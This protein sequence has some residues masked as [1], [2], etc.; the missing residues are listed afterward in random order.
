MI[1]NKENETKKNLRKSERKEL[2]IPLG[3]RPLHIFTETQIL[4]ISKG[5]IFVTTSRPLPVDADIDIEFL[6]PRASKKIRAKG[7]VKW[8]I[9]QIERPNG[10]PGIVPGMGVKFIKISKESLKEISSYLK[11]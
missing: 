4:N 5:G 1:M 9:D 7:K 2:K 8:S 10:K 3:I 6:I 11:K